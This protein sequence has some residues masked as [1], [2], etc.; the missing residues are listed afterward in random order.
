MSNRVRIH[1]D[2]A[3]LVSSQR[4]SKVLVGEPNAPNDVRHPSG[5]VSR[6]FMI[7][8]YVVAYKHHELMK[9]TRY[10][11]ADSNI[12]AVSDYPE[13]SGGYHERNA[14]EFLAR[15]L[16]AVPDDSPVTRQQYDD[17]KAISL[18]LA[19]NMSETAIATL[20]KR[21]VYQVTELLDRYLSFLGVDR[22]GP[23]RADH[24]VKPCAWQ[25]EHRRHSY[26]RSD[27][28]T[29]CLGRDH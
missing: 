26:R 17:A 18:G 9:P 16:F 6:S 4:Y 25:Y 10:D 7:S 3:I 19:Y 20:L 27:V 1:L 28:K 22:A 15:Q 2:T 8:G 14:H 21:P 23:W 11:L 29:M 24:P 12:L 5:S 13:P